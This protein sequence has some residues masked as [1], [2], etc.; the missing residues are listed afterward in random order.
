MDA[1]EPTTAINKFEQALPQLG[2]F[3]EIAYGVIKKDGIKLS[4]ILRFE[5]RWV[6]L[7]VNNKKSC[8]FLNGIQNIYLPVR[9][10]EG[11]FIPKDETIR[12]RL[13]DEQL[14]T[15]TYS[16]NK[17]PK[18]PNGAVDAIAGPRHRLAPSS[19][20]AASTFLHP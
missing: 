19:P 11:Q 17:Y 8:A 2:V 7:G 5:D 12:K 20:L 14:V 10:G 1:E 6:N 9:H 18:N 3:K 4:Q 15:F 16:E 13:W